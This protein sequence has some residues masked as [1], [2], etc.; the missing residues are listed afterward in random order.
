VSAEAVAKAEQALCMGLGE[1]QC[2]IVVSP[3][4]SFE[5]LDPDSRGLGDTERELARTYKAARRRDEF[6]A[7]RLALKRCVARLLRDC[8][9]G[10]IPLSDMNIGRTESRQPVVLLGGT[11]EERISVS[12]SHG[13]GY[14]LCAAALEMPVGV[15]V[16]RVDERLVR[17][18]EAYTSENERGLIRRT[19][20]DPEEE[21]A[22]LTRLWTV[23]EAAAK[24]WGEGMF[25]AFGQCQVVSLQGDRW[26][27]MYLRDDGRVRLRVSSVALEGCVFSAVM[28]MGCRGS[29]ALSP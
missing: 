24:C 23:K 26:D 15:D 22:L 3:L 11:L 19:A 10:D 6:V 14:V 20:H 7:G 29:P 2:A 5:N 18:S 25:V 21:K 13:G 16:E 12:I 17:L 4:A 9:L 8:G 28:P 1:R 27:A